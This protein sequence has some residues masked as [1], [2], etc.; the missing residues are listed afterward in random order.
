MNLR[1]IIEMYA[2]PMGPRL[3][4]LLGAVTSLLLVG[5]ANVSILLLVRGAHRQQELA[6]R[7]A[8]GAARIRIVQQLLTEA[9]VIAVAGATL[10]V[11][12]AW[13]GLALIVAWVPTNSFAAESVIEMNVPVLLFST[14]LAV[15]TAIVFG[16]WPALQLSRPDIGRVAQ[17]SARRVIGSAQG[18]K[19]HRVMIAVQVALTLLMLTAAGAAGKGFLRLAN[20]DLGY[21]PQ[22]T[23]SLPIPV[24]DGTYQTWKERSE[25]FERLRAAIAGDA[26]GRVG[27]DLDQRHAAVERRRQHASRFSAAAR[28][29]S[30]SLARISSAPSISRFCIFRWR[31]DASGAATKSCEARRW[32]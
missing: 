27:G 6:V 1:S 9:L 3:F 25:Y 19:I 20:A 24:H 5:C 11:L 14:A 21:D 29:K 7:A 8:L 31:K 22:N 18:R 17:T 10:G 13:K 16:V 2:R 23:M 15:V 12:I 30:R 28:S 4:L 32:P 26:A